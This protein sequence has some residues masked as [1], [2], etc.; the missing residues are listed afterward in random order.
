[1]PVFYTY[2]ISSLPMLH[3]GMKPPFAC[4]RFIEYCAR[5]IPES[6]VATL[7]KA[8]ITGEYLGQGAHPTLKKW[9]DFDTL[10]RNELVKVRA[11]YLHQDPDKYLRQDKYA[12]TY[13]MHIV[14]NAHRIPSI[15]DAEKAL[16]E[17][18]W[19]FLDELAFGHYFDLEILLIY[20]LKLLILQRW[21]RV[22]TADKTKILEEALAK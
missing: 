19:R 6:D 10:L 17:E 15:L 4:E 22:Y 16:D 5:F 11:S 18:R 2:L 12:P 1:M 3:F 14:L 7:K 21:E 20:Y 13:I 8:S 9:Q